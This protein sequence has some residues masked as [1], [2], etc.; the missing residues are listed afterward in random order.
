MLFQDLDLDSSG[1]LDAFEMREALKSMVEECGQVKSSIRELRAS[2]SEKE[3]AA[4]AAQTVWRQLK[5]AEEMAEKDAHD[6]AVRAA[7]AVA[8][9]AVAAKEARAAKEA[10]KQ[11]AAAAD[12][13]AFEARIAL[14]RGSVKPSG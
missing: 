8:Q 9:A 13:A 11:A 1:S 14:K 6:K 4:K 2:V 5:Q 12:K 7:E 3:K 10:G